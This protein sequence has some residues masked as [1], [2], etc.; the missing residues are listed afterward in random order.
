MIE[1]K[2][3]YKPFTLIEVL[4][5]VAIIGILASML[6]PTLGNAWKK[7]RITVCTSQIKQVNL[8]M[9]M[10]TDD[11]NDYFPTGYSGAIGWED[12]LADY[13]GRG[14]LTS[15]QKADSPQFK[16][17]YGDDYGQLYRCPLFV[18]TSTRPDWLPMTYALNQ[19]V[20]GNARYL[21]VSGAS[22]SARRGDIANPDTALQLGEFY[23]DRYS[24][25]GLGYGRNLVSLNVLRAALNEGNKQMHGDKQSYLFIDGHIEKLSYIQTYAPWGVNFTDVTGSMWDVWK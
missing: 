3:F 7:A 18:E 1:I 22:D 23:R 10:Y 24:Y 19:R 9:V 16:S 6:L 4:V 13:D 5:V 21:G 8:A 17:V 15:A 20:E 14:S 25:L 2:S 11:N 12:L